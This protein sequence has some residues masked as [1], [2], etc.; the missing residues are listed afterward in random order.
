[1]SAL[2]TATI[3]AIIDREGGYVNDPDDSGGE[4][5]WGITKA[6]AHRWGYRGSMKTL[7][8]SFAAQ[9]YSSM[10]WDSLELDSIQMLA[11]DTAKELADTGVNCGTAR[12]AEFL[13]RSLNVLNHGQQIYSDLKV[14]GNIGQK[15]IAALDDYLTY[16]NNQGGEAVLVK[17]LNSLQGNHYITLAER[18]EKD[19]TFIF[20]WFSHRVS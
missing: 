6:V 18:R 1:M 14:D 2:K 3:N 20:G 16:R 17:M 10:Y 11:P 5:N 8:R 19:E 7:Q 15:S 9:I 13:Q 4:T 12:A